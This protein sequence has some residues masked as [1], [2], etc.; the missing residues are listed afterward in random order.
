[1]P[2]NK[3]RDQYVCCLLFHT[4]PEPDPTCVGH[5]LCSSRKDAWPE[6]LGISAARQIKGFGRRL[7]IIRNE[8]YLENRRMGKKRKILAIIQSN[9]PVV[10]METLSG[11]ERSDLPSITQLV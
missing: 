3:G 1:M 2:G 10:Q 8:E 11:P 6:G 4:T 9:F 7:Y 5:L